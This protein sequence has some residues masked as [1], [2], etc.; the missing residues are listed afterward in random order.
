LFFFIGTLKNNPPQ[1]YHQ[2][3]STHTTYGSKG[4]FNKACRT[5]KANGGPWRTAN[6]PALGRGWLTMVATSPHA[7]MF[8]VLVLCKLSFTAIKPH[9]SNANPVSFNLPKNKTK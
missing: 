1:Y 6:T 8:V 4:S 9:W 5:F 7:K 3:L 2:H